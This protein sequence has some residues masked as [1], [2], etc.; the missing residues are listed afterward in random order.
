[1][2]HI[3]SKREIELIRNSCK[4]VVEAFEIVRDMIRPGVETGV[5]DK[6]VEKYITSK[7]ARPAFKGYNGFPAS[8][9]ISVEDEV[10]HGIPGKRILRE[11]EIVS[12]D[13]GVECE[14]FFGD[15]ANT[16]A[17]GEISPEKKRLMKVT[18]N[19]L[20]EGVKQAKAGKRLSDISNTIQNIVEGA[21]FSVVRDLVGH[22]IG[23]KLHEDPQIPNY[24]APNSGPRL[25]PGMVLA[26]EPMVNLG[27]HKVNT[28]SDNWTVITKDG[29]PSA[30][31]EHTAVIT[32]DWP[33]ILTTIVN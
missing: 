12:V 21:G 13:I 1:M 20:N 2:I 26:I 9:C 14:G 5:I 22:G 30:H 11:G 3:R 33:D 32:Q 25:R 16:Y 6:E 28:R 10:V 15:S 27:T 18:L 31:F 17:V 29:L 7:G 4:I 24:G 8:S 19:A 23:R